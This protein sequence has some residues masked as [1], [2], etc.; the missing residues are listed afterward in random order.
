M[1]ACLR[2][3]CTPAINLTRRKTDRIHVTNTR[4][5]LHLVADRSRPMDFEIFGIERLQ[6]IG[7]AAASP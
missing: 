5:E 1:R 2:L 3:G 4:T 7:S 6:A